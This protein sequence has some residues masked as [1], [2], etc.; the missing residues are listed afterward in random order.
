MHPP[1]ETDEVS[2]RYTLTLEDGTLLSSDVGGDRLDYTP[3]LGHVLPA[4]EEALQGAAS[5]EK[6]RVVLSPVSDP[7]LKLPATRLARLLGHAGKPLVL[8]VEIL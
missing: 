8:T 1:T 3:G 4:L 2:I 6:R 7:N 5:G